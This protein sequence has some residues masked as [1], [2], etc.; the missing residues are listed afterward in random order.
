M[1]SSAATAYVL[2]YKYLACLQIRLI[3]SVIVDSI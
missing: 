1:A 3:I 2:Q